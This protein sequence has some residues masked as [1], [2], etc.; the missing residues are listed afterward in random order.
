MY[1][2]ML[3]AFHNV[4]NWKINHIKQWFTKQLFFYYFWFKKIKTCKNISFIL[5]QVNFQTFFVVWLWFQDVT[6]NVSKS[7]SLSSRFAGK[8]CR[9][10]FSGVSSHWNKII[11]KYVPIGSRSNSAHPYFRILL[12]KPIRMFLLSAPKLPIILTIIKRSSP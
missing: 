11:K 8:H 5:T 2:E 3:I 10:N 6:R 4:K 12:I 9:P 1:R 7:I